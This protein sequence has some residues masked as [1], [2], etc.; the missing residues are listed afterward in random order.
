MFRQVKTWVK[1]LA[2]RARACAPLE[3]IDLS[4]DQGLERSKV[5]A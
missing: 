1:S 3:E 5:S 2:L 4:Y